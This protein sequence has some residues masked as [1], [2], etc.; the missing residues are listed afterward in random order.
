VVAIGAWY[1]LRTQIQDLQAMPETKEDKGE[2]K[3][4]KEK[5]KSITYTKT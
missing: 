3:S 1:N 5:G 2:G 4:N